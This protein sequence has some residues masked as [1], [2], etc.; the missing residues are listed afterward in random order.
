MWKL[1]NVALEGVGNH[2]GELALVWSQNHGSQG[3]ERERN[4]TLLTLLSYQKKLHLKL[5]LSLDFSLVWNN[6][7]F[8]SIWAGFPFKFN[9]KNLKWFT[10]CFCGPNYFWSNANWAIYSSIE[11]YKTNICFRKGRDEM[12][13]YMVKGVRAST[14]GKRMADF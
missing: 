9:H 1:K 11:R 8:Q 3:E 13:Q 6:F 4:Q 5:V 10:Y 7:I 12:E 2:L 14:L